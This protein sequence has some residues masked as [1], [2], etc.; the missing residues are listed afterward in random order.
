MEATAA[1]G[2]V[3]I[4]A[5][6]SER[7]QVRRVMSQNKRRSLV[8]FSS[9]RINVLDTLCKIRASLGR[10]RCGGP[11][12]DLEPVPDTLVIR[13]HPGARGFSW[14]F[15]FDVYEPVHFRN[16]V[17]SQINARK[18]RTGCW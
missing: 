3:L 5:V 9:S 11:L 16:A 12:L 14:C 6:W 8:R 2:D 18:S 10:K 17:D 1:A 15:L 7:F 4:V 13:Q